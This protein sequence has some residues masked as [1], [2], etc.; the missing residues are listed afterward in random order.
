MIPIDRGDHRERVLARR[1]Q[2]VADHLEMVDS[3]ARRVKESLPP[4]FDLE[5]LISA[6]RIALTEAAMRYRPG[7]HGGTPFSA[8]A[9]I[10]VRGAIIDSVR[11][12]RYR[13]NTQ[14]PVD[15]LPEPTLAPVIDISIDRGR[16][17]RHV[18]AAVAQLPEQQRQVLAKYYRADEPSL[19]RVSE[20]MRLS[21]ARARQ[22]HSKAIDGLR[23]ILRAAAI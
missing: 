21:P 22:I 17:W 5:D 23:E 8:Y 10:P 1:D 9:R 3:I 16:L 18:V 6:G 4:A 2:L 12:K 20:E 19:C 7:A 11:G 13:E 14:A 15:G